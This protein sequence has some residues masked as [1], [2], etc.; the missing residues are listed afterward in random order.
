MAAAKEEL[1]PGE[2]ILVRIRPAWHSFWVFYFGLLLCGVGPWLKEDPPLSRTTGMVFAVVFLLLILRRWSN[3]YTLTNRRIMVRG[4][5]IARE[6]YGIN[7]TDVSG[8]ETHQGLTLRLVKAGHVLVRSRLP[9]EENI[10]IYG[11]PDPFG[12]KERLEALAHESREG[13]LTP[14]AEAQ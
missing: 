12:F 11:L 10:I 6:T 14:V 4:G 2:D 9:H 8:V 13:E 1:L 7:L 3:V 5:L